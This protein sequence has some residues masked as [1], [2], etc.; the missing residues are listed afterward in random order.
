MLRNFT[1]FL[2]LLISSCVCCA[3]QDGDDVQSWN[4]VNLTIGINE[5]FDLYIPFTAR[6]T[7]DIS[8]LGDFRVGFGFTYKPT[9]SLAITPF[10]TFISTKNSRGFFKAENRSALRAVYKFPK[11]IVDVSHRSQ[12]ELRVRS[13]GTTWRYRPSITVEKALPESIGRGLKVFVTEEPFYDSASGRFSRNRFS[14]G[15][16]KKLTD[17]ISLDIYYLRQG[18]NFSQPG[19]IHVVGTTWKVKL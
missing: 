11:S 12:I 3:Q 4:E 13:T 1:A 5:K 9:K 10:H 19:T 14:G 16:G 17:E 18:D 6:I 7:K 8:G 15:V 2:V